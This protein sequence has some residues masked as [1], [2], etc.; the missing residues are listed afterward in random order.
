M[1]AV[2]FA[3]H[4]PRNIQSRP[5][6]HFTPNTGWMNDPNG[7]I[8]QN[9][10]YQMFFQHNPFDTKWEN[11]CWG[12]ATSKDLLHWEQ[13][14][15][16]LFPDCDGTMFSGSGIVNERGLLGLPED[17]QIYFYTC[18][19]NIG[20]WSKDKVFT[21]KI[22]YSTDGG[23]TVYKKDGFIVENFADG[24]RDPKVYW[25]EE[26]GAYYMALYL[27]KNDFKIL[28]SMDLENWETSDKCELNPS[29]R[30]G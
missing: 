25:H 18:A 10:V 4:M 12:H 1:N 20:K 11:M 6:I 15:T 29:Y 2:T 19:G 9:G 8:Y 23:K 30:L 28:R 5:S 14:D 17:A 26:T 7:L 27:D 22:A 13:T 21:Q 16:A 24:N 3:D